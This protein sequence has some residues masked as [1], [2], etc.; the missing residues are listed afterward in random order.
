MKPRLHHFSYTIQPKTLEIT[1]ELFKQLGCTISYQPD[2]GRWAMIEQKP[3]HMDIQIIEVSDEPL[4]LDTK[5]NTH[6]GFVSSNPISDIELLKQWAK[7]NNM[8]FRQGSWSNQEH[9]FDLPDIF[10]NFVIE[11]M[12]EKVTES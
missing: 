5:T 12:Q 7:S 8:N 4:S 6:I 2:K 11:I 10:I 3:L 1:L 9:W